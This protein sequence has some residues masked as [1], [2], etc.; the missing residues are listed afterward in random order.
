MPPN[1]LNSEQIQAIQP[2]ASPCKLYDGGGLYLLVMPNGAKYWRLKYRYDGKEKS[3]SLGV[4]PKVSL[5]VARAGRDEARHLLATGGDPMAAKREAAKQKEEQ[6][7]V[8]PTFQL[9]MTC[10]ALTIQSKGETL[11][12]TKAQTAAVRAFFLATPSEVTT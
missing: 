1:K 7:S 4:Y 3:L 5:A 11:T 10:N 6:A 12:L 8:P 9:L 2:G